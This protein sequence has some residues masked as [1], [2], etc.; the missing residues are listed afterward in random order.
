MPSRFRRV[1]SG[2]GRRSRRDEGKPD[3][4]RVAFAAS[5]KLLAGNVVKRG[6]NGVTGVMERN[7]SSVLRS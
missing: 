1:P 7:P 5:Q 4:D 6:H 3:V 2:K